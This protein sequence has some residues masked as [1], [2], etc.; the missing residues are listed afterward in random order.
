MS[1]FVLPGYTVLMSV[2]KNDKAEYLDAA[3]DSM[4][5]QT[6]APHDYVV[7]CDGPLT[8]ELDVCLE[9]WEERLGSALNVVRLVENHGLGYALNAG[10]HEC[11]CDVVARMDADDISR[12]SRCEVLLSKMV[13]ERLDLVG[14][15]IEEFDRE[16]GDM[17]AVRMPP[18][19]IAGRLPRRS[20]LSCHTVPR[21]AASC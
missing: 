19:I 21:R 10:L 4:V 7:V 3:I 1:E 6:V 15:A 17:R 5:G 20:T 11:G 8:A 9:G 18:L 13:S 16:P 14:G 12:P 2:Y